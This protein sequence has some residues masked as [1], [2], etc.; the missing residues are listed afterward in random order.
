VAPAGSKLWERGSAASKFLPSYNLRKMRMMHNCFDHIWCNVRWSHQP[1]AQPDG[2]SSEQ[3]RWMLVEDF[4]TS[5]NN[6][7]TRTFKQG[8]RFKADAPVTHWYGIGGTYVNTGLLMYL[9][10]KHK[11]DNGGEIQN[12]ANV[13]LGIIL[14]LK[15]VKSTVEEKA[16]ASD[17]AD[18]AQDKARDDADDAKKLGKGTEVFLE[19]TEPYFST[20]RLVTVDV[21]FT[22]IECTLAAK[23]EGL[24]DILNAKQCHMGYPIKYLGN[25]ILPKQGYLWLRQSTRRLARQNLWLSPGSIGIGYFLSCRC[26]D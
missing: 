11:S 9:A 4:V 26:V 14:Q 2:I 13:A 21:Y 22:S 7:C 16:L 3:Y 24:L 6:H 12:L 15:I 19:L 20:G 17:A 1:P 8:C 18:N 25:I 5:Y 10:L 23:V